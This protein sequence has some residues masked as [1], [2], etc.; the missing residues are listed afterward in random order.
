MKKVLQTLFFSAM[1]MPAISFAAPSTTTID[2]VQAA[3]GEVAA[4]AQVKKQATIIAS[5]RT[6]IHYN[7][8][9]TG[10]RPIIL[11][12]AAIAPAT[13]AT[14]S[15]IVASNPALSAASQENAKKALLDSAKTLAS[16]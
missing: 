12:T 6:G 8:G 1:V 3:T 2:K 10:T 7:L 16:N 13:E 11:K 4:Q 14:V 15:R 9:E 5:P